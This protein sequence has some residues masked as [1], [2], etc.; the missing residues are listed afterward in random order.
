MIYQV[1][2]LD[3]N[4]VKG[5]IKPLVSGYYKLFVPNVGGSNSIPGWDEVYG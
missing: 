3:K 5:D 4:A 2:D 1:P